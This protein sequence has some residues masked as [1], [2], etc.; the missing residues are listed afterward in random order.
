MLVTVTVAAAA[1][2]GCG[3]ADKTQACKNIQQEIQNLVQT[4][5]QQRKDPQALTK[6]LQDSATKIRDQ[7]EPVGGDLEQAA[8]QAASALTTLSERMAQGVPQQS[9]L[10]PL[11]EAGTRIREACA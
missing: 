6:T 7:G 4:S 3:G 8:E 5:L 2:A 1:T 9:D 10:D 11:V